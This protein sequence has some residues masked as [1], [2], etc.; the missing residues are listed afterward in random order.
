SFRHPSPAKRARTNDRTH[1]L[2]GATESDWNYHRAGAGRDV[3]DWF[4]CAR[5]NW[6]A[7][8]TG[9]R[10]TG[11]RYQPARRRGLYCF[12]VSLITITSASLSSRGKSRH[13]DVH[14]ELCERLV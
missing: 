3:A 4:D 7:D 8:H 5:D 13:C 2:A 9:N 6:I 1:A 11:S 10:A 14:F 12:W